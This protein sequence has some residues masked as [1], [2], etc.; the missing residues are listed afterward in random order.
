MNNASFARDLETIP[1]HK[2][3][4][5]CQKVCDFL[6]KFK[7]K[8]ELVSNQSNPVAHLLYVDKNL[9]ELELEPD[10]SQKCV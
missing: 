5:V 9:R 3:I 4:D 10:F 2:D 1:R 7:E 8:T 6:E